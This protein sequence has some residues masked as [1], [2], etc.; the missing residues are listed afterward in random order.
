MI[1]VQTGHTKWPKSL[2]PLTEEQRRISDDFMKYW[3]EVLP[4]KYGAV[5]TFN[6]KYAV[7][8]APKSFRTTLEIGAG[9]GEHL[10]YEVLTAEQKS[11]YHALELRENMAEAIRRRHRR[12]DDLRR[13][14]DP[15]ALR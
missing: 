13:L 4:R 5:E 2:P 6:H 1:S 3:H 12:Q 9:L 11:G 7:K 14:P 15:Y 8:H 10:N